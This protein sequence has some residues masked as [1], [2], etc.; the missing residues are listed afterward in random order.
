MIPYL[1][2]DPML[3]AW[4]AEDMPA[5]DIT[6]RAVFSRHDT[7]RGHIAAREEMVVAGIEMIA[8]R[9]FELVDPEISVISRVK[10]GDRVPAGTQLLDLTGPVASILAAERLALNLAMRLSG[11]STLTAR[12]VAATAG[13]AAKIADTRKTTPGLRLLEKYA[14]RCGG[15]VN[16]R[17]CLSDGVLIKDNHIAVCGS[18]KKAVERARARVPHTMKIEVE[19]DTLAQIKESLAV[20][21]EIIMLD[22]MDCETMREGVEMIAG[23]AISEA[24]G[25]MR[26][27]RI[28]EVAATGVELISVGALTHSAPAVDMGLD[29][30]L[31]P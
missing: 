27:E 19:C 20:G 13:T 9:V 4:L 28:A 6:G 14:V 17:F 31:N 21:V 18:I 3:K 24:S 15:G 5:G 22:N 7:C 25:S 26:V 12:F 16:H 1:T 10:D 29:I 2:L 8:P 30:D 11:I 23:R